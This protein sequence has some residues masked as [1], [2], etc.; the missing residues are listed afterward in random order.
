MNSLCL[1]LQ[2]FMLLSFQNRLQKS[3]LFHTFYLYWI[4][5]STC[6][7]C[8]ENCIGLLLL[9]VLDVLRIS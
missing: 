7:E 3:V 1:M 9:L 8:T 6:I 5:S 4:T 2:S